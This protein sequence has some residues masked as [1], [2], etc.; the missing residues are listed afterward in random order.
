MWKTDIKAGDWVSVTEPLFDW[1]AGH[2]WQVVNH[3]DGTEWI[4]DKLVIR[5]YMAEDEHWVK[6]IIEEG[7]TTEQPETPARNKYMR[8]IAPGVWVDVYDVLYAFDVTDPCLQHLIKKALA[9]GLRGHKDERED[10]VDIVDSA[11]RAVEHYD[12][13]HKQ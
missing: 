8:E 1:P 10:L 6:V 3:I 5:S 12:R 9:T 2:V 4:N 11:K 7:V 13:F